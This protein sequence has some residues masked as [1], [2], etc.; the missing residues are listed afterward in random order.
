MTNI[1]ITKPFKNLRQYT[2]ICVPPKNLNSDIRNNLKS[3]L[4]SNLEGRCNKNGFITKIHRIVDYSDGFL[5]PETLN[6]N[7]M[8]NITYLCNI[9]IPIENTVIIA[10]VKIINQE[11]IIAT[12][13]PIMI[14]IPKE[15]VDLNIWNITDGYINKETKKKLQPFDY[16]LI[17]ILDKRI[18]VNELQIK[19]IGKLL[20]YAA[21][22]DVNIYF[23]TDTIEEL[24]FLD[25]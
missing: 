3:L 19:A 8:Y 2:R 14:F 16:V 10:Q 15:N 25:N 7:V 13:G 22:E 9:C 11:L 17:E 1:E 12:N 18:N 4:E 6:G 20:N 24:N 23:K 5:I 21:E